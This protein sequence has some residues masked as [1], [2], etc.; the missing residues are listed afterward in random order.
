MG[1]DALEAGLFGLMLNRYVLKPA[2]GRHRPS[3][4]GGRTVFEPASGHDSFPS[5]H[6][7]EAFAV[8]SVVAARSHGWIVPAIA[9]FGATVVA[10]DR[11][12]DEAHFAS[13]VVAGGLLG[14]AIGRFLVNRHRN[15]SEGG[16]GVAFEIVPSHRGLAAR[17]LF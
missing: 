3:E 17:I 5:G 2:F 15:A 6:A 14:T 7:T 9:Y 10:M 8:A 4:S 12:N 1:R 11:V 16:G 13:D